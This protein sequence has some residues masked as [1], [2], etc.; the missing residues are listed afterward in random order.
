MA[1]SSDVGSFLF[2]RRGF[3]NW[4]DKLPLSLHRRAHA[5]LWMILT[6]AIAMGVMGWTGLMTV[7]YAEETFL[8]WVGIG[9][10]FYVVPTLWHAFSSSRVSK[11]KDAGA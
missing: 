4:S 9:L 6:A 8:V 10:A 7:S 5:S 3:E 2:S 11:E 1:K